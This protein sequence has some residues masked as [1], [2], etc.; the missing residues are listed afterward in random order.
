MK[1]KYSIIVYIVLFLFVCVSCE[2]GDE[3]EVE[4]PFSLCLPVPVDMVSGDAPLRR[5]P[6]DPGT[7]ES[8]A[9]PSYVYIFVLKQNGED[10][11]VLNLI[12]ETLSDGDWE[13]THYFGPMQTVG[14][15]IYRYSKKLH[16]LL[17]GSNT[18]GR[19]Y[20]VASAVPLTFSRTLNTISDIDDLLDLK[21]NISA[22]TTQDN[23]HNIYSTPYNY[24]LPSTGEYYGSFMNKNT[25]VAYLDLVLYHIAAKVDLK[26]NVAEENRINK[27]DP[28]SAV[29]LTYMEVL[30]L[31]NTSC[32][33]FRPMENVEPTLPTSGRS[34]RIISPTDE[35]LWWEGRSY[36]YTIP[37]TVTGNPNYFPLQ[38]LMR[39]NG[40][41]GSGY[42]PVYNLHVDC[43]SPFV[44]W[45]RADFNLATP[46]ADKSETK[47]ID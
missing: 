6:G 2:R 26:W 46:L 29:R 16:V 13:K 40:S 42:R 11:E 37:Y 4:I 20:A 19:V 8:F 39:T 31:L 18:K 3:V 28:S 47:T 15:S 10:W 24:I 34:I 41:E 35:G 1:W 12:Q 44:P 7:S 27:A 22:T 5:V 17:Q 9:L 38:M 25:N 23:L 21:I 43:T 14:D 36:F 32:Y 45:L 33:A 30:N